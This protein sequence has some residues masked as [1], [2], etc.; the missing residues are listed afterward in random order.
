MGANCG[1]GRGL[2]VS[3]FDPG[4][5]V[6]ISDLDGASV[7]FDKGLIL[8]TRYFEVAL[9]LQED[10]WLRRLAYHIGKSLLPMQ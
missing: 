7:S 1:F 5:S 8:H 10:T 4:V 9:G 2:R 3:L 6:L